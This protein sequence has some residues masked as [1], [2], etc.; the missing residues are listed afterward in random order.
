MQLA[1]IP[2]D[3]YKDSIL[4]LQLL[5]FLHT[6]L[7]PAVMSSCTHEALCFSPSRHGAEIGYCQ[8]I[9]TSAGLAKAATQAGKTDKQ[10]AFETTTF[11]SALVLPGDEL[12]WDPQYEEQP[13]KSWISEEYRNQV[14]D[15]RRTLYV[16]ETPSIDSSV[17]EA[18]EWA[19][20]R[21]DKNG[22]LT[23]SRTRKTSSNIPS[24]RAEDISD[25]LEAF[26]DPMPVKTLQTP[27]LQFVA[28]DAQPTK[29]KSSTKKDPSYIGLQIGSE[30]VGIR[31]RPSKDGLYFG[32]LNLNDI[33]DAA[34][35]IL[36]SD[37]YAMVM[38]VDHDLYEDDDDDFCC[39]RAYGGSRVSVVSSARYNPILD[40]VQDVETEHAWPASHCRKYVQDQCPAARDAPA[41]KVRK[42]AASSASAARSDGDEESAL[43]AAV[44][45]FTA[46][47]SHDQ[48]PRSP[49]HLATLWFSRLAKTASHELGHCFGMDH[50]VYFACIMQGTAGLSEDAR[51][52]PYLCPVDLAK[53][54]YATGADVKERY[55]KLLVVC[56]KWA[57]M[58]GGQMWAAWAAW[59]KVRLGEVTGSSRLESGK[60]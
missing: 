56:E 50:C 18:R 20:P 52:P 44:R 47:P 24:P 7:P 12:S 60:R 1:F 49:T 48:R 27:A 21:I 26:Y 13:L 39:G 38:L 53:V 30:V 9:V 55:G 2:P 58:E 36:P 42:V 10:S 41:K 35:T 59:L 25:Y 11:P 15:Q 28:W 46:H 33:L 22:K 31:H 32:Q 3:A 17:K 40:D 54:V 45:A 34:I 23:G 14:T 6:T 5:P 4:P 43:R 8:H 19:V 51:Q 57:E 29:K 37:A 16:V